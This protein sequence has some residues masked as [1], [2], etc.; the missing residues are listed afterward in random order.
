MVKRRGIYFQV[1]LLLKIWRVVDPSEMMEQAISVGNHSCKALPFLTFPF[2]CF[3]CCWGYTLGIRIHICQYKLSHLGGNLIWQLE[4]LTTRWKKISGF[5]WFAHPVC[6]WFFPLCR[7]SRTYDHIQSSHVIVW[8]SPQYSRCTGTE[9]QPV[10]VCISR[11]MYSEFYW[12]HTLLEHCLLCQQRLDFI[13]WNY[14]WVVD[15]E[16]NSI[17]FCVGTHNINHAPASDS[18]DCQRTLQQRRKWSQ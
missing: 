3:S 15:Q 7:I 8:C 16:E 9:W 6:H 13:A 18:R 10:C 2:R 12:L 11:A 4:A 14:H 17:R 5:R 1:V